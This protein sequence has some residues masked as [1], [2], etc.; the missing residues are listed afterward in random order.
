M[1]SNI[2]IISVIFEKKSRNFQN[3]IQKFKSN[4][5]LESHIYSDSIN[6]KKKMKIKIKI[7]VI[8]NEKY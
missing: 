6:K 5:K 3:Y 1:Y 2:D 4:R 7:F 8:R